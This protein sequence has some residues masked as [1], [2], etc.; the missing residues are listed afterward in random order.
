MPM[1]PVTLRKMIRLE[2]P[3]Y[4]QLNFKIVAYIDNLFKILDYCPSMIHD[5]LDLIFDNLLQIDQNVTRE[6]IELAEEE[7]SE[8]NDEDED[9][10][11]LPVAETL[12]S[13]MEKVLNFFHKKLKDDSE[14]SKSE[15]ETIIEAIF[16]YF[17]EHMIKTFTRHIHFLL[18]YI[19]SFRVSFLML[20]NCACRHLLIRTLVCL[21]QF[22]NTSDVYLF[23][24]FRKPSATSSSTTSGARSSTGI[25]RTSFVNMRLVICRASFR[26]RSSSKKMSL[27]FT[28]RSSVLG[29]TLTSRLATFTATEVLKLTLCSTQSAKRSFILLH[30]E[31]AS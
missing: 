27:R 2:F 30:L 13:C 19:A 31:V 17:N 14:A 21:W 6:A 28:S 18:F 4:K 23:L 25:S 7:E 29:R 11:K 8:L 3:Y 12:D 16:K 9:R 20:S 22:Q 1:I 24:S 15:Q 5:V 10:M 26:G